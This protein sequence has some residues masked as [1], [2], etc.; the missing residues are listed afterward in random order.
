[1]AP[2]PKI[3]VVCLEPGTEFRHFYDVDLIAVAECLGFQ[4]KSITE[5]PTNESRMK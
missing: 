3:C 4:V 2:G 1:M 5:T